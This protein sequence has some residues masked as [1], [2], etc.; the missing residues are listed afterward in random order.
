MIEN[1]LLAWYFKIRR[2]LPWRTNTLFYPVWISEI[3]LQQT[4]VN[5]ALGFYIEF[6]DHFP[7]LESLAKADEIE[8][9]KKWEGLGYYSRARNIHFTAK[10]I[11]YEM[12]NVPPTTFESLKKLKGIGDYTA[13]AIASIVNNEPVSAVDGNVFRVFSRYFDIDSDIMLGKTRKEFFDIGNEIISKT[14]PGDFNQ[15]VMEL[16]ATI[17]T[18]KKAL[19]NECPI[20]ENC[21]ALAKNK[22]Y[23][24]PVKIKKNKVVNRYFNYFY[25]EKGFFFE[26]RIKKGIWQN[27]Y[28]LPLVETRQAI[29]TFQGIEDVSFQNCTLNQHIVHKLSHQKLDIKFWKVDIEPKDF[30]LLS[31]TRIF[32]KMEEINDL[33]F[34]LPKPIQQFVSDLNEFFND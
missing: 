9:L 5:Q 3:M 8:V 31:R 12:N 16:G 1:N 29:D 15:A 18:P 10:Y 20:S 25:T 4:R 19:C 13:A 17:C 14:N 7:T 11:F 22:V 27:L 2:D 26:Q 28:Q 6:M 34:P 23:S 21:L 30:K 24:L 33:E 32:I